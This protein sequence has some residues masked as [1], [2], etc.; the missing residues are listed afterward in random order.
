MAPISRTQRDGNVDHVR[1]PGCRAL[2]SHAQG[3]ALIE[4]DNLR[5]RGPQK[6]GNARLACATPPGLS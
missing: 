3:Q 5:D 2:G 4:R 1:D 6:P